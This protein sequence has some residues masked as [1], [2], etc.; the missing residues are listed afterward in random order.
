VRCFTEIIRVPKPIEEYSFGLTYIK[1]TAD[2]RDAPGGNAF[3]DA[4]EHARTSVRWRYYE[5]A[6]NHM[7]ASNRPDQLAA[8]LTEIAEHPPNPLS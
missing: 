6:T 4:A 5:V 3:W 8:V 2:P 7:V 1:A